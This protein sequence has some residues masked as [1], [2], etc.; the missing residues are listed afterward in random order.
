[1]SLASG[2]QPC[3]CLST[4][5]SCLPGFTQLLPPLTTES[6]IFPPSAIRLPAISGAP[7]QRSPGP[8]PAEEPTQIPPPYKDSVK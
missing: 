2:S 6:W 5:A 3:F 1:M 4:K 8:H 7:V